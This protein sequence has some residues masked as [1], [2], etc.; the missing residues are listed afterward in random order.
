MMM[1]EIIRELTSVKNT[2]K[3]T[4]EQVLAGPEEYRQRGARE[5]QLRPQKRIKILRL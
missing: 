1:S 5:Y 2:N 3:I 4:S